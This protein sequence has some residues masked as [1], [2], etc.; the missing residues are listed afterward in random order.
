MEEKDFHDLKSMYGEVG[1]RDFYE[2]SCLS[3]L[4][5]KYQNAHTVKAGYKG[6]G[7]ID[8]YIGDL[9]I[10]PIDIYQCKYF[11]NN[12]NDSQKQQIK[13]SLIRAIEHEDYNLTA[14]YLCLPKDL[15]KDEIIWF[16]KMK[17]S[18][19]EQYKLN[20]IVIDYKEGSTLI[21]YA[22][23]EKV[24]SSIF[25]IQE[26]L[27]IHEIHQHTVPNNKFVNIDLT[28]FSPPS[29]KNI[30][31]FLKKYDNSLSPNELKYINFLFQELLLNAQKHGYANDVQII[32][33]QNS[34]IF[35][36]DGKRFNP[37]IELSKKTGGGSYTINHIKNNIKE[38]SLEYKYKDNRNELIITFE[39]NRNLIN[40]DCIVMIQGDELF[41]FEIRNTLID[42]IIK[43]SK[44]NECEDFVIDVIESQMAISHK[45]EIINRIMNDTTCNI[46]FKIR[47][48]DIFFKN[49]IEGFAEHYGIIDRIKVEHV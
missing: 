2:K 17:K 45:A 10:N 33:Q 19:I 40:E 6:D 38:L 18:I 21:N 41:H 8:I 4:E 35:I 23:Q 14:W 36:D 3:I 16:N 11:L 29:L 32:K 43:K 44:N 15:T 9:G 31:I 37:L 46:V 27:Q 47:N 39:N 48:Q 42:E 1:A 5:S 30:N 13:K 20:N 34:F 26:A 25:N 12:L 7:G 22:K 28:N 49:Y 24:Y